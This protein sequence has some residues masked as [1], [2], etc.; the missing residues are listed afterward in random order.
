MKKIILLILL[1][2]SFANAQQRIKEYKASNQVVYKEG[3]TITLG[4][5]SG[6]NGNFVFVQIS[7][8]AVGV[9]PQGIGSAYS[10]L[11]VIIKKIKQVTFKGAVKTGF[12]VGGGNITNY[13]LLI[14][15]AIATCEIKDC[16]EPKATVISQSDKFDKLKKLKELLN[17]GTLTQEEYDAEKKKLKE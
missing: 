14:E 13:L 17:D 9:T 1:I 4:R 15:D 7:G 6:F 8:W 12:I 5:G 11:N 3:D 10:G 16:V 2:S